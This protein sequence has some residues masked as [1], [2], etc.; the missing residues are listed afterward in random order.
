M[1]GRRLIVLPVTAALGLALAV[2]VGEAKVTH[3]TKVSADPNGQIK[4]TKKKLTVKHGK[5]TIVFK[6][7]SGSGSQHGI[8]VEGHGVD[9]D[10][11]IINPGHTTRLK[12]KLKKGKYTFYCPFDGHRAL[13]MEGKLIVK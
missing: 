13:G 10:G 11:K 1:R 9:K 2:G 5:V 6:N 7:P 4:F 12:V 3:R 8:A